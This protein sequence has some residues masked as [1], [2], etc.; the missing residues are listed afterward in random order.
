MKKYLLV[1][2]TAWM[3]PLTASN[4]AEVARGSN[5][6]QPQA[7]I[8]PILS[9]SEHKTKTG[10]VFDQGATGYYSTYASQWDS[11][12]PFEAEFAD[13]FTVSRD[14]VIDSAVW[15]GGYWNGDPSVPIGFFIKIYEDST[16]F[17][18]PKSTP[19]FTTR[20][21]SFNEAD[22]GGFYR[23]GAS[24]P[25]FLA[26]AGQTYWIVFQSILIFPPQWG[27]NGSWPSN[28]PGWGDGQQGYMRFPLIGY[29]NW[30]PATS[31][32]SN[33]IEASFQLFGSALDILW[34]FET[35]WQNW[36][37]TNGQAFPGGWAVQPSNHRTSWICPE[38][39]DSSFWIDSDMAGQ[40]PITDTAFSPAVV[41]P[42][43]LKWLKFGYSFNAYGSS[44]IFS[45]GIKV[46]TGGSWQ[47]PIQL[48]SWNFDAGPAWD[49]VDIS[50]YSTVD[51]IMVF[52]AYT[53]AYYDWYAAFDN[54]ELICFPGHDVGVV[55]ITS[56]AGPIVMPGTPIPL[57]ATIKNYTGE[58]EYVDLIFSVDSAGTIIYQ[59]SATFHV[60]AYEELEYVCSS[61]WIPSTNLNV[62]YTITASLNISDNYPSNNSKSKIVHTSYW[63]LWERVADMPTPEM[64]HATGYDRD[65]DKIY[66]FGGYNGESS[67]QN[68]TYQY[69]PA[70]NSW[71][72]KNPMPYAIDWINASHVNGK[73]YIFGGYD[74]NVHDYNLIYD[75]QQDTWYTGSNLP[76]GRIAGA[77]VV[78]RDSLIY[79][80]GGYNGSTSTN[81]VQIYD[82]FSNSWSTG[83]NLPI[84]FMMGGAAITGDT[85]W[86]IGGYDLAGGSASYSNLYYGIINSSDPT[87]ITWNTGTSLPA[88]NFNGG[89]TTLSRD[90]H[91]YLY[92]V[93]GFENDSPSNPAY[94]YDVEGASW[95]PLSEYPSIIV[96]NDFLVARE[97]HNEIYVIGGDNSGN[98][99]QSAEVWKLHWGFTPV[100]E[101]SNTRSFGLVKVNTFV[102]NNSEIRYVLDKPGNINIMLYDASG[103][104]VNTLVKNECKSAGEYSLHIRTVDEKGRKLERGIYF[105]RITSENK[106]ETKKVFIVE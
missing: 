89:A 95:T 83:T 69:D 103:R 26:T 29:T 40:I 49:S 56:P 60:S 30:T 77:Q 5:L 74:G 4:Y 65:N 90:G 94:E 64:C 75:V 67:Y 84:S 51:S 57:S 15:W 93:G 43:F 31:I 9:T 106:T 76:V 50:S 8:N 11:V 42:I 80:L 13:N 55:A 100:A 82:I 10:I 78:Y 17:N 96:R 52:F 61:N 20:V 16:G 62:F 46:F 44:Q 24:F 22:V 33:P 88:P 71:S 72:S 39:G 85:I 105:L 27:N 7:T 54:V 19:V 14:F 53:N 45:V 68:F 73:F 92:M 28:T 98:W 58:S 38:P 2:L 25:G 3:M 47:A 104:T 6:I 81:N 63:G 70:T 101:N 21:N 48:R 59:E 102:K 37:H 36:T 97:G 99:T 23:Y 87:Q 32:F 1:I 35:G 12:Y 41:P 79:Y 91:R 18:M 34:D 86:I 66:A